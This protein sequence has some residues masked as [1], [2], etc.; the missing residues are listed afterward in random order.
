M[1]F[2][3][4][5]TKSLYEKYCAIRHPDW[6]RW[7]THNGGLSMFWTPGTFAVIP[8]SL[9][10]GAPT[11]KL[12]IRINHEVRRK[13]HNYTVIVMRFILNIKSLNTSTWCSL[14]Q[15]NSKSK[16]YQFKYKY[17]YTKCWKSYAIQTC[18][19]MFVVR[20]LNNFLGYPGAMLSGKILKSGVSEMLFPVFWGRNFKNSENYKTPYKILILRCEL[21][22]DWEWR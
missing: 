4:R 16:Q 11:G 1:H 21:I 18:R 2:T 3:S 7:L 20:R 17:T 10:K 5:F 6:F 22:W 8:T 9:K 14:K 13:D 15:D 12:E 19:K